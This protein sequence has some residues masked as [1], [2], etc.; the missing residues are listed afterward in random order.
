M[1]WHT[2]NDLDRFHARAGAFLRTRP[3]E[4]T[5]LLTTLDNV[6]VRGGRSY[7]DEAPTYGWWELPD[8][9]V[10]GAYLHTPPYPVLVS[11]VPDQA[12]ASLVDIVAA[13]RTFNAEQR[14]AESVAAHWLRQPG[15][16]VEPG[17][18]LRLYRLEG[19]TPPDRAAPGRARPA[20]P[21]DRPLL[22]A[23][24]EM[25][26]AELGEP[27]HDVA[28]VV[29]E[30]I[31][32]GGLVL[33]QDG[34]ATVSMAGRNRIQAGTVRI[35]P[36]FTPVEF[37]GRGYA[38]AV[39]AEVSH[40]AQQLGAEVVLFTDPAN[41]TSNAIYQRLGYRPIEDR[42]VLT[43]LTDASIVDGPTEPET[44]HSEH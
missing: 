42:A 38:S 2:T 24:Y 13:M 14:L 22:I 17:R 7:G 3:A 8:G 30:R 23:W 10:G 33:W 36:V 15:A 39:T 9:T 35:G 29:D 12:I 32:Y 1:P 44:A 26:G 5:L 34:A 6:R 25:F 11:A 18:R 19:L 16:Q 21:S 4:N 27:G 43:L 28:T 41:P 20:E 31:G 37:R 40:R